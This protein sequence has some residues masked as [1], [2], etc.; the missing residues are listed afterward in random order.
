MDTSN[1]SIQWFCQ[2]IAI[3]LIIFQFH[4]SLIKGKFQYNKEKDPKEMMSC[5][6]GD[7]ILL[8]LI[9]FHTMLNLKMYICDIRKNDWLFI[10]YS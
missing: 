9:Q 3:E 10:L 6:L 5:C 7:P 8:F 2:L 1:Y 4:S